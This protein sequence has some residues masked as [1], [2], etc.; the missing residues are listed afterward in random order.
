[1]ERV[2]VFGASNKEDRYSYKALNLLLEHGHEVVPVH[3]KLEEI[4][5]IKVI[6][7]L[8]DVTGGVDTITLYV[9]P[10]VGESS[11]KGI[12]KLKPKR[13]IMNPG[14]E[15]EELKKELEANNISVVIGC[16]LIMLKTNQY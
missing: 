10:K 5:G 11:A 13:V 1:M 4:K 14:T 7:D 6:N 16:T 12:I 8:K 9:N 3:P 15:S 2:V